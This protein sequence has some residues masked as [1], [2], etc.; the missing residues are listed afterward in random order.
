[1]Q[2]LL[3]LNIQPL[4]SI[5]NKEL[6]YKIYAELKRLDI[7]KPN[8]PIKQWGIDLNKFSIGDSEM[9]EKHLQ[10]W[11]ISLAI[12]EMHVNTTLKFH[13]TSVRMAKINNTSNSSCWQGATPLLREV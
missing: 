13:L 9:A 10:K 6:I 4:Y 11:S 7:N 1:M 2:M 8:N 5:S 3:L 12:R